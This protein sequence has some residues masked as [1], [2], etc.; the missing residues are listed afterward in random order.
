MSWDK[1]AVVRSKWS[2]QERLQEGESAEAVY[3][4]LLSVYSVL[5]SV[6]SVL[7]LC[8]RWPGY[9]LPVF[10]PWAVLVAFHKENQVRQSASVMK[11]NQFCWSAAKVVVLV[12]DKCFKFLFYSKLRLFWYE[13]HF[14]LLGCF[15]L[16]E[17]GV[18]LPMYVCVCF[19][20]SS[21]EKNV[22]GKCLS[23]YYTKTC[24]NSHRPPL[25]STVLLLAQDIP[26]LLTHLWRTRL[27]YNVFFTLTWLSL[28]MIYESMPPYV[29]KTILY[30]VYMYTEM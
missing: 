1:L 2:K 7:L 14:R 3:S 4:V 21:M 8:Q 20:F 15:G 19:F 12:L 17:F 13:W 25:A 10:L 5:L 24:R 26:H 11:T 22:F 29:M 30:S 18:I 9:R 27:L 28:L 6:Y 16:V 23:M